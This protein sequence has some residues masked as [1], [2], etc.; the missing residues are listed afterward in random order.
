MFENNLN[1]YIKIEF[2][3]KKSYAFINKKYS[4]VFNL[5]IGIL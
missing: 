2:V 5:S 1:M 4:Y 3:L